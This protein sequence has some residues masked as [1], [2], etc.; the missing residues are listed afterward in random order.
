MKSER[1][2]ERG[3]VQWPIC[4]SSGYTVYTN[5]DIHSLKCLI[6]SYESMAQRKHMY[7]RPDVAPLN[8]LLFNAFLRQV[9]MELPGHQT[10]QLQTAEYQ[11][12]LLKYHLF[13]Y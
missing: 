7:R 3:T 6:L 2:V 1:V 13:L 5:L 11:N 8:L 10:F 4:G 9:G 12:F